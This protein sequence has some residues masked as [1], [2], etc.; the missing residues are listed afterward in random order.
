MIAVAAGLVQLAGLFQ[1]FDGVQVVAAGVLRGLGSV[2]APLVV[3]TIGFW[4]VGIP[5]GATLAFRYD[6]GPTGLWTGLITGLGVAAVL[7]LYAASRA[8]RQPL[9]RLDGAPVTPAAPDTPPSR[10][11]QD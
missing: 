8:L 1:V 10:T 7:M 5:L 11:P 6:L 9:R 2:R 4:M 3:Q